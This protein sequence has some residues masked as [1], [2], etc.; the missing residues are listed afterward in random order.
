MSQAKEHTIFGQGLQRQQVNIQ[1][2]GIPKC[3]EAQRQAGFMQ[4]PS[5]SLLGQGAKRQ[6]WW[7]V[8]AL[9]KSA[10]NQ[11]CAAWVLHSQQHA[12]SNM[13]RSMQ[14]SAVTLSAEVHILQLAIQI[15]YAMPS[16]ICESV[17][18][19]CLSWE[20]E[21]GTESSMH[22]TPHIDHTDYRYDMRKC[23]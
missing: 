19:H 13:A 18:V 12:L 7:V 2:E 8:E 20:A 17:K 1:G 5:C 9:L 22:L 10:P 23:L 21:T 16:P 11:C 15:L 14:I 6:D 3:R 4:V